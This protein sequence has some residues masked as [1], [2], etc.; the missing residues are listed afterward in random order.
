[1]YR[2][3][4]L[5]DSAT[6]VPALSIPT[7]G[8]VEAVS[9]E[10]VGYP[11]EEV[12]YADLVSWGVDLALTGSPTYWYKATPSGVPVVA[13][14]P[15]TTDTIGVQFWRVSV[16]L[17]ADGDEPAAPDRWHSLIVDLAVAMAYRD[18]DA[19]D[20]AE[21]LQ[22]DIDR[23]TAQMVDELVSQ[24]EPRYQRLGIDNSQ[25]W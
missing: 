4:Y 22:V 10:T 9:N 16:D 6:G 19:H 21:A 15:D 3:S 11:L 2:W 13:T 24:N 1:M 17:V 8:S 7:L 12:G 18:G 5:E 25:D 23:Q 14:Y 20:K